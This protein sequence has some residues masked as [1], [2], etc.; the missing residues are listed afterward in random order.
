MSD[1][2]FKLKLWP[3][4]TPIC[5]QS[6]NVI[7]LNHSNYNK[8]KQKLKSLSPQNNECDKTQ[9]KILTR[10]ENL[11]CEKKIKYKKKT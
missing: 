11:T 10:I 2:T 4:Q 3:N 6:E 9:T 1:Y 5:D 7:K 8:N